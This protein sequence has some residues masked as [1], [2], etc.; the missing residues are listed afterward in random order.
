MEMI[1][2]TRG[3][4]KTRGIVLREKY[5]FAKMGCFPFNLQPTFRLGVV[6]SSW[7]EAKDSS[8]V[9]LVSLVL[10]QNYLCN[11]RDAPS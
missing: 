9:L 3:T 1:R 7:W 2:E 8:R 5:I 10:S 11:A 6:I 4:R